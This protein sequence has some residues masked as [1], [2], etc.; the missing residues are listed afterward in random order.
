[1]T[2]IHLRRLDSRVT[3]T[4]AR[5]VEH[6][7]REQIAIPDLA[8]VRLPWYAIRNADGE[9]TDGPGASDTP[10]VATVLVFDEIGGSLGVNAKDFVTE[11]DAITAPTIHVRINSRG[12]ALFD[13]V[14]IHNSLRH[15]PSRVVTFVDALAASAASIVAMGGDEVV[16]MPGSQM[17]IHDASALEDGNAAD[18][19]AMATFLDRQSDNI[20]DIYQRKGGGEA[21]A[22]RLL[23]LAETWMF[24]PGRDPP[25]RRTGGHHRHR[26]IAG[27]HGSGRASG[28]G[29]SERAR[30][31]RRT[32]AQPD[33]RR[34]GAVCVHRVAAPSWWRCGHAR[35]AATDP[36]G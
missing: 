31:P 16:M 14:A 19:G 2:S 29:R 24:G 26:A 6:A 28:R 11:L 30:R 21:E 25:T 34:A 32:G 18:H 20:A 35:A 4:A 17:M 36:Q 9:D 10:D 5:I 33:P 1:M 12:G 23:M 7:T 27:L 22:W 15:H 8:G 13:A 3:H